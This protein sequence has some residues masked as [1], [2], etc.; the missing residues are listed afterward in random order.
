MIIL[1]QATNPTKNQRT[2]RQALTRM[3]AIIRTIDRKKVV[4]HHHLNRM[5]PIKN[6]KANTE[7]NQKA[8]AQID[9]IEQ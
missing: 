1:P 4:V 5:I 8:T 3:L 6:Q 9:D 7:A 2:N